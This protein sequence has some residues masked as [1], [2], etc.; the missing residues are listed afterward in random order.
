MKLVMIMRANI[1]GLGRRI[2]LKFIDDR[3]MHALLNF[4]KDVINCSGR[5]LLLA[6]AAS[7]FEPIRLSPRYIYS[8]RAGISLDVMLNT[9]QLMS[10]EVKTSCTNVFQCAI[11]Y[12]RTVVNLYL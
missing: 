6:L 11:F 8:K 4:F 7:A 1:L 2:I 12:C 10:P 3:H 9:P 5:E